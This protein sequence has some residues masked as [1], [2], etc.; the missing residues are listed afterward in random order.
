MAVVRAGE[1]GQVVDRLALL[2]APQVG[3]GQGAGEAGVA[4]G[5]AGEHEDVAA[6]GVGGALPRAGG[7]AGLRPAGAEAQLGAEDGRQADGPGGLG[8]ADHAVEA[9]V[10]GEGEGLEAEAGG[11]DGQL[12]GVAGAV[13][14]AEVRVAVQLGVGHRVGPS[15]EPLGWLV[16]LTPPRP[17]RTVTA[18]VRPRW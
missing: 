7:P 10:V 2:P 16:R 3:E 11:L 14:E 6:L 4:L 13:E 8:E 17:G 15:L 5:V 1:V 12:L 18:C 9:V